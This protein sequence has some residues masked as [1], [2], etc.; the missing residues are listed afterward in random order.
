MPIR[1]EDDRD[2]LRAA[3]RRANQSTPVRW[4]ARGGL[5]A[6][7]VVNIIIGAIAVSVAAGVNARADQ[8]GALTAVAETPGGFLVLWVAAVSLF[9]LAF[10]Q[11]T[12]AAWVTAPRQSTR[13]MRRA[14]DVGKALGF[15]GIGVATLFFALGGGR[16]RAAGGTGA[17]GAGTGGGAR[18]TEDAHRLSVWLLETPG[19]AVLLVAVALVVAS[20][21]TAHL[22]RGVSR[23]FS[24]ELTPLTGATRIIVFTLGAFGHLAKAA[25]LF[26][27]AAL[28]LAA[29][30]FDEPAQVTGLDGA[31]K[32][33]ATLP[34]GTWL[35]AIVAIGFIAYGLYL[36]ARARYMRLWGG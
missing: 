9:G 1:V 6:N 13:L 14:T 35:L 21:A 10:W 17:G 11:L 16:G 30:V 12:D 5:V 31:L 36:F 20:I 26:V 25:G 28:L 24:E 18:E 27:V 19:G 7:G 32:Y 22:I 4:L 29:V 23:H 2:R 15:A 3:A 8:S 33:L 34:L